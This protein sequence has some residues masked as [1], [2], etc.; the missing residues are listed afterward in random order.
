MILGKGNVEVIETTRHVPLDVDEPLLL[1][2]LDP[3]A[4]LSMAKA[5]HASEVFDPDPW[6]KRGDV[7]PREAEPRDVAG[8]LATVEKL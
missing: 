7:E 4:A 5:K 6:A 1:E 3:A 2:E 8:G